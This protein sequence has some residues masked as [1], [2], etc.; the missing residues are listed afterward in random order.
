MIRKSRQSQWRD[1]TEKFT[2][3]MATLAFNELTDT[4]ICNIVNC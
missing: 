4:K 3:L 1:S 2:V